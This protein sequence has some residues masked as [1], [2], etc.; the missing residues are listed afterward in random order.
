MQLISL[1]F[2]LVMWP[3]Q[4]SGAACRCGVFRLEGG[5]CSACEIGYLAGVRIESELLFEVLDAHGHDIDPRAI[6]CGICK[7]AIES[8]S[9]CDKCRIG[10]IGKRAY[11]SRLT[12]HLTKGETRVLASIKCAT[13]NE[14]AAK[15]G[16]CEKCRVGMIGNVAITDKA[17]FDRALKEY[18]R[19]LVAVRLSSHCEMCAVALMSNGTCTMCKKTYKD[20]E[21]ISDEEQT[22]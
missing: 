5:W 19:L 1:A 20:G 17:D 6:R 14:G 16:W 22:E 3:T 4:T 12:Y 18:R 11:M 9:F 2:V 8:D 7:E 10:W 13:C 21:I 15:G